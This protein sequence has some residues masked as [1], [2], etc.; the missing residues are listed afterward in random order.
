[1][2][3]NPLLQPGDYPL[4]WRLADG[5]SV[6]GML[7]LPRAE[8]VTGMAYDLPTDPPSTNV[9][10]RIHTSWT[11]WEPSTRP[12]GVVRGEL[13]NNLD[14]AFPEAYVS[15]Q[16][17][18][19]SLLLADLAVGEGPRLRENTDLLFNE[20]TFQV[21][22]LTELSGVTPLKSYDYPQQLVDGAAFGGTWNAGSTQE[23]TSADGDDLRMHYLASFTAPQGYKMWFTTAPVIT[24][25]GRARPL[26][27]WMD[28]YVHPVAELASFATGE[29]QPITFACVTLGG[30]DESSVYG[31]S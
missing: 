10:A 8:N 1:M 2:N 17:P 25:T 7:A 11:S 9:A 22:G 26:R 15:H 4:Q 16:L 14:V 13:R 24:V 5:S 3:Q 6:A 27:E 28:T 18:G 30:R 19:Q 20:I 31:G 29:P 23:W 12:Y 21:G